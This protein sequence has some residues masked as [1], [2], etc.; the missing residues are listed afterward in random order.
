MN[1][2]RLPTL[3]QQIIHLSKYARWSDSKSRRETWEETVDRYINYM[4]DKQCKGKV[5]NEIR[6]EI[7]SAILNLEVMPSMRCMMTAGI[8]LDQNQIAGY[9]CT[10]IVVDHPVVFDEILLLLMNGCGVGFS[11]ERQFIAS[12]PLVAEKLKPSNTVISVEDS[13]E[14]WATA[15]RELIGC[16]YAGSVPKWDLSK[17]R[18]AGSKLKVFGGRASGPDP[19]D[20]M[21]RFVVETF[22]NAIGR[23]LNSIECHDILCNIA[24][25]VVVGGVRRSS[26]ISLSN[27]SDDRMRH[28]KSGDWWTTAPYRSMANNCLAKGTMVLKRGDS[29]C[30][31]E[32]VEV[33]DEVASAL[34]WSRVTNVFPQGIRKT[35]VVKHRNGWFRC[36]PEHRVAVVTSLSRYEWKRAGELQSTDYLVTPCHAVD[37][38]YVTDILPREWAQLPLEPDLDDNLAWMFG[39]FCGDGNT[40]SNGR[41]QTCFGDDE[42]DMGKEFLR[43]MSRLGI[44]GKMKRHQSKKCWLV[45]FYSKKLAELMCSV[46]MPNKAITVPR[47]IL[48]AKMSVRAAFVQGLMDAD[49][50]V[51]TN[52]I[53]VLCS[54]FESSVSE[55]QALMVGMGIRTRMKMVYWNTNGWGKQQPY[56]LSL[57]N[58]RD[59]VRF[60]ALTKG[61]GFKKCNV[62]R[63]YRNT[64][65]FPVDVVRRDGYNEHTAGFNLYSREVP[66][67]GIE[68]KRIP[69]KYVPSAV[70]DVVDGGETEVIDLEI[71]GHRRDSTQSYV[72]AGVLQ[73]NSVAYTEKPDIGAFM[74]EWNSLYESKSGERGIINRQALK[75]QAEKY[76]RRDPDYEFIVNPCGEVIGRGRRKDDKGGGGVCNLTEVIIRADD[77]EKK[78]MSKVR[79]AT[80]LGTMQASLLDFHYLREGWTLNAK[81]EALLGVSLTG[82]FDNK[83]MSGVDGKKKLE[84]F[85]EKLRK[86]TESENDHWAPIIGVSKSAAITT[87]KPSGTVSLLAGS[88]SGIHP[89]FAKYYIRRI[90]SDK[91]DPLSKMMIAAGF[92]HE[93]DVSKPDSQWVFSFP[94]KSPECAVTNDDVS[95]LEHLSIWRIYKE[96]WCHHNPSITVY[97]GENEWMEVGAW[98]YKNFDIIGGITFLPRSGHS[99]K[100][101][102]FEEFTA[103]EYEKLNS[104]MPKNV[105]WTKLT[106][107]EKD[108]EAITSHRE[109]A[110]SG[111]SCEIADLVKDHKVK[112]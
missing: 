33:G 35:V 36:T 38:G 83:L 93:D 30:P 90:R 91:N 17:I 103:E 40:G 72:A 87:V 111:S 112:Q 97:V 6:S 57:I 77:D 58:R 88:A 12:L 24:E 53:Q 8:A 59:K 95:A 18:P 14:G 60:S 66:V 3:F 25:C 5:S 108:D 37:E 82:I 105:D 71:D 45:N 99:Y 13:K 94:M 86:H 64:D 34:G 15:L 79:L 70:E 110:C 29:C 104:S 67:D 20:R 63:K 1:K 19:L 10:M 27:L 78:I 107:Y 2:M 48:D 74:R 98:V 65:G 73:H 4:F 11:V 52:P 102:P 22:K 46:K 28:A 41:V 62:E 26:T 54:V 23:R 55:V 85:L 42:E 106:E 100:Q 80:I 39:V 81:E 84:E 43:Q 7:R 50:S 51:K 76:G 69:F 68:R 89:R 16:L 75:R 21:F 49:G 32:K 61:I 96:H 44:R 31:I 109:L 101:M 92:P 47:F 56:S 9:N